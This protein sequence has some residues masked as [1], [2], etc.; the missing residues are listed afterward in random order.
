MILRAKKKKWMNRKEVTQ[1]LLYSWLFSWSPPVHWILSLRSKLTYLYVFVDVT[2]DM[3][4]KRSLP[5]SLS[6]HLEMLP[7]SFIIFTIVYPSYNWL[8]RNIH[9]FTWKT[10][11]IWNYRRICGYK[12]RWLLHEGI[13]SWWVGKHR[14][15]CF[16]RCYFLFLFSNQ[17]YTNMIDWYFICGN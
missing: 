11:F 1:F 3:P 9:R 15:R 8:F 17:S 10:T 12:L 14:T 5:F 4:I 13:N 7:F 6:S 2:I 16:L